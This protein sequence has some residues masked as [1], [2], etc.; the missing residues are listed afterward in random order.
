MLK[1]IESFPE[2]FLKLSLKSIQEING[3]NLKIETQ[4]SADENA[5]CP[6]KEPTE[7]TWPPSDSDR[8]LIKLTA[9]NEKIQIVGVDVSSRKI[10]IS[11]NGLLCAYRGTIVWHD[12]Y[13][14]RYRRYGPFI[15]HINNDSTNGKAASPY[16]LQPLEVMG[17]IQVLLERELQEYTCR[18]FTDSIILFDGCLTP[19][20][21]SEQTFN[22]ARKNRNKIL[23]IAKRSRIFENKCTTYSL[24]AAFPCLLLLGEPLSKIGDSFR[25]YAWTFAVK[26]CRSGLSFRLDADSSLSFNEVL[27]SVQMLM[28]NDLLVHG[29]PETLRVA[30]TLSIFTPLETLAL[31]R[32]LTEKYHVRIERVEN[33][34]R[35]LFGPF[36]GNG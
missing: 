24:D 18:Q 23:A 20:S 32:F 34:R 8:R 31:Q 21:T 26:L 22:I 28:G 27:S 16:R 35:T 36:G 29:Y 7:A 19:Q 11:K 5:D 12:E 17:R 14:Y 6:Y 4:I 25:S 33:A 30:H 9:E 1:T 13:C 2:N 3:E 15:F 10:G